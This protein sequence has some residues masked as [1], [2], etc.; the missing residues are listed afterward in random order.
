MKNLVERVAIL[1]DAEMI[2]AKHLPEEI[3]KPDRT[4]EGIDLH[5]TW[6]EFKIYKQKVK[7]DVVLQI[8][9]DFLI[10]A[11][12]DSGG[13][14]SRAAKKIRMQR[15]NFHSLLKKYRINVKSY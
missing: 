12:K 9:K 3:R 7:N 11:L 1:C 6:E 10:A 8:E 13:N 14:V 15:T 4:H 5:S 2:E